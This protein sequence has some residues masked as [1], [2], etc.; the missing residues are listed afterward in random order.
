MDL[1]KLPLLSSTHFGSQLFVVHI[2]LNQK[3]QRQVFF[4]VQ[5]KSKSLYIHK[6]YGE[7]KSLYIHKLYGEVCILPQIVTFYTY[8]VVFF[9]FFI[10]Y[11]KNLSLY[12]KYIIVFFTTYTYYI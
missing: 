11:K 4:I 1:V 9:F 7:S 8:V 12:F 6:V 5:Q 2:Y 3:V 10:N